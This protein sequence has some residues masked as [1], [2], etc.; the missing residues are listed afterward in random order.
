MKIIIIIILI[1]IYLFLNIG[2]EDAR[3]VRYYFT[4][5]LKIF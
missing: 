3:M 5:I 2:Q 4:I 1:I